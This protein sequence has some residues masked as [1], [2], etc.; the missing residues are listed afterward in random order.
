[1]LNSTDSS[2]DLVTHCESPS[3]LLAIDRQL[4]LFFPN[5]EKSNNAQ[6]DCSASAM[7][8]SLFQRPVNFPRALWKSKPYAA[9]YPSTELQHRS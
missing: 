9:E 1:M 3:S 2:R 7:I 6:K 5:L 8:S 4:L